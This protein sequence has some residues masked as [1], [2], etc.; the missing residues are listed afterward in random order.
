M[1][2]RLLP[3]KSLLKLAVC[4]GFKPYKTIACEVGTKVAQTPVELLSDRAGL[5]RIA[6]GRARGR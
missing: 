4:V 5:L 3:T 6:L 1:Y 2:R